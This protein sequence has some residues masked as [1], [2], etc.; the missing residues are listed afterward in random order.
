MLNHFNFK[1]V[2]EKI[3]LLTNDFGQYIFLSE[4][5]FSLLLT[6][7]VQDGSDLQH[8]LKEKLF[9]LEPM[10]L[11]SADIA[12][13][14]REIKQYV[15]A[16]TSLHIFV[17][18]NTC[19]LQCVYCQAQAHKKNNHGYMDRE[20]AR[21]AVDIAIQ[22]PAK[23]LT[24]EFQGGEP[25]LN[26]PVIQ[27]IVSY[28]ESIEHGKNIDFT[29][30]SNLSLLTDDML[31]F[32]IRHKVSISTSLDGPPELHDKNRPPC[33]G[34]SSHE[35]LMRAIQRIHER[36]YSVSGI[37]TTTKQSL[38]YAREIVREYVK[39][40]SNGVFIRP[41]TPL[42][43][44]KDEWSR[45]GYTPEEFL[46][47]YKEAF[48]E[49]LAINKTGKVFPEQHAAI[50]LKKILFGQGINYMDLR[51]PCGAGIGQLAYYYDGNIY[52]CDE[53]RM[54]AESGDLAF[55]LGHVETSSY[56]DVVSCDNCKAACASSVIETLPACCD[57][58]YQPYC[59]VCPVVNYAMEGDIF[60]REMHSYRCRIYSGILDFLFELLREN[61]PSTIQI[62]ESWVKR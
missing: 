33:S 5:E 62:L 48:N 32:F 31:D 12:Q 49:V 1:K 42:G 29:I 24:F 61:D 22:S 10:D 18:T 4:S 56:R 3:F 53:A 19:N 36:N 38:A 35:L 60:P 30:V 8:Q 9:L 43:F 59:G 7:K 39:I 57:C 50:L 51:S 58:V 46:H 21:K 27:E 15:F 34:N 16:P 23:N 37:E 47:F 55:L 6:Q 45:I 54:V 52:T 26:Y 44:A 2:S 41:L 14:L 28:T 17:V 20:T 13:R 11:F 40:G 25:L